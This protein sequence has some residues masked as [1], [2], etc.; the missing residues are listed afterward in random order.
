MIQRLG[1]TP[2]VLPHAYANRMWGNPAR[3][4][5]NPVLKRRV[6][7]MMTLRADGLWKCWGFWF[8]TGNVDS[9]T[10][11][12]GEVVQALSDRKVDVSCMQET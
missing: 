6:M 3:M 4:Q 11:R 10:G 1:I 2:L 5:H 9:L 8:S 12:A 7:L